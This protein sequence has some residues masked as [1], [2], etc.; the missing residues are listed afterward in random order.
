MRT[1]ALLAALALVFIG[2]CNAHEPRTAASAGAGSSWQ[3]RLYG[4]PT[5]EMKCPVALAAQQAEKELIPTPIESVSICV[6]QGSEI[7]T[8]DVGDPV[9]KQHLASLSLPDDTE[10]ISTC[11]GIPPYGVWVE[12]ASG[13]FA[14]H[15]PT[16][17]CGQQQQQVRKDL[18]Y[19]AKYNVDTQS[20]FEG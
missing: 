14:V 8:V 13:R 4:T 9:V 16:Y 15:I 12:T 17:G 7:V 5:R 19:L 11:I 18:S 20:S 1:Q 2:G 10:S 3:P 6:P